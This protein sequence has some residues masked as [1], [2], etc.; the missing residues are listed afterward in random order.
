MQPGR[1]VLPMDDKH[2]GETWAI[3]KHTPLVK[4][5]CITGLSFPNSDEIQFIEDCSDEAVPSI[6]G[7]NYQPPKGE[8][9]FQF[10]DEACQKVLQALISDIGGPGASKPTVLVVDMTTHTGDFAR[11]FFREH[12]GTGGK[13]ANMYYTGFCESE[14]EARSLLLFLGRRFRIL[15]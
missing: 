10:G 7:Q 3:F 12:F 14:V 13:S 1:L 11:A 8:R 6:V 5:G 9:V 15:L 2:C 4:N